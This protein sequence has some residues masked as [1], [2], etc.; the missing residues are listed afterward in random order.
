MYLTL[1]I[2]KEAPLLTISMKVVVQ[3]RAETR[4]TTETWWLLG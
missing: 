4:T 3:E 1:F 2:T